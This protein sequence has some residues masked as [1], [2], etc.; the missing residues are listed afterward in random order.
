MSGPSSSSAPNQKNQPTFEFT[1]RKR[2]A[3]LLITELV[4]TINLVLSSDCKILFCGA[5]VTDLLGWRDEDLVDGDLIELINGEVMTQIPGAFI[6][7]SSDKPTKRMTEPVS[8]I[9]SKN[10]SEHVTSSSVMS[11][12]SAKVNSQQRK[13]SIRCRKKSYSSSRDILILFPAKKIANVSLQSRHPTQVVIRPCKPEY[14]FSNY[15]IFSWPWR[16]NTFLDLKMENE[17]LQQR[18]ADLR[19]RAHN[20][21]SAPATYVN[22]MMQ[23]P[24]S[25]TQAGEQYYD[26]HVNSGMTS[27]LV[28]ATFDGAGS[29]SHKS[30]YS[31]NPVIEDKISEDS[32]RKKVTILLYR[33]HFPHILSSS[34]K[35]AISSIDMYVWHAAVPTLLNGGR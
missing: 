32:T 1:K 11:V 34:S 27:E 3:D 4:G 33:L 24:Y 7:I 9:A 8:E 17:R 19:E 2:F 15:L 14:L 18:V 20:A 5:A 10:L 23:P 28:G 30:T 25:P 35:G 12:S 21:S 13:T 22:T 16:L 29:S 31:W 26:M 6:L